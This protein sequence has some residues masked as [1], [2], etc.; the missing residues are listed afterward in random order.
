M[1]RMVSVR[2]MAFA[3][4]RL[5]EVAE[6]MRNMHHTEMAKGMK[7]AAEW[8]EQSEAEAARDTPPPVAEIEGAAGALAACVEL[9]R[10]GTAPPPSGLADLPG[11]VPLPVWSGGAVYFLVRDSEVVYVGQSTNPLTRVQSHADRVAFHRAFA[12]PVPVEHLNAVE[13]ALIR[14]FNPVHN[15]THA[16]TGAKYAPSERSPDREVLAAL[17]GAGVADR[18]YALHEQEAA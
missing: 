4:R 17:L 7:A 11:L 5:L 13:G 2:K 15:A 10:N 9:A 14:L 18:L 16:Y 6:A 1:R 3:R 12:L 8:W